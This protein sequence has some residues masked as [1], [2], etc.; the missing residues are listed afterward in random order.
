ML[1]LKAKFNEPK[2]P[3]TYF[4]DGRVG[5]IILEDEKI[6]FVGEISSKD[7]KELEN[8]NARRIVRN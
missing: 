6:G 5:E 4:I 1:D 8:K 3:P 7:I 2:D